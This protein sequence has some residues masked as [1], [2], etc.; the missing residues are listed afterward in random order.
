MPLLTDLKLFFHLDEGRG[1]G[2]DASRSEKAEQLLPA[3]GQSEQNVP[4]VLTSTPSAV[5]VHV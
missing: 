3:S 5:L 4:S 2:T 1:E